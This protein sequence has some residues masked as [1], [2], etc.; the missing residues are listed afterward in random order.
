MKQFSSEKFDV[1]V[2]EN[3]LKYFGK[4]VTDYMGSSEKSLVYLYEYGRLVGIICPVNMMKEE[5]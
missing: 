2:D 1:Y 4:D 5:K 3:S